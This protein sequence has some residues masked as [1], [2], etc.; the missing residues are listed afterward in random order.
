MERLHNNQAIDMMLT[1]IDM[2][3]MGGLEML[4]QIHSYSTYAVI[5]TIINYYFFTKTSG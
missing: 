2:P 4:G 3:V 5:S 1:E